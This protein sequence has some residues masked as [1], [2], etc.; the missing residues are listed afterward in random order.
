MSD[1]NIGKIKNP[2]D[3]ITNPSGKNESMWTFDKR[4]VHTKFTFDIQLNWKYIRTQV[5]IYQN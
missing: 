1:K 4:G 3:L 2:L 5:R